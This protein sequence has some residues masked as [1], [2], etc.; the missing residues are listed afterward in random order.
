MRKTPAQVSRHQWLTAA[1]FGV[2]ALT[3]QACDQPAPPTA[4]ATGHAPTSQAVATGQADAEASPAPITSPIAAAADATDPALI[5]A[6]ADATD[7]APIAAAADATDP[8]LIAAA[9]DA[10]DPAPIAAA[11]DATDPAP[12]DPDAAEPKA[13]HAGNL[14]DN[15]NA[16]G[17]ACFDY[18]AA[19]LGDFGGGG[20]G[21][22]V[23]S[24]A[25]YGMPPGDMP[26]APRLEI[27]VPTSSEPTFGEITKRVLRQKTAA[28][29][30]CYVT[31]LRADPA[32]AGDLV[33]DLR[34]NAAGEVAGVVVSQPLEA[35]VDACA[36]GIVRAA[37]FPKPQG[38][39]SAQASVKVRFK[40]P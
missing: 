20:G 9:A 38:A 8:A 39:A 2:C 4:A 31:A 17:G 26:P 1:L 5:A 3:G 25:G 30:D 15:I 28:L 10:T 13:A 16:Q 19:G 37:R 27:T 21:V 24:G 7:P 29:R 36:L 22:G 18:K 33:L 6:A 34:V 35:S 32:L 40:A 12:T 23:I 14:L 11:A